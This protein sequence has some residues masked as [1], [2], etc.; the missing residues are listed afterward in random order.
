MDTTPLNRP[1]LLSILLLAPGRIL[2]YSSSI[3]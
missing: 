2:M 1:V 3:Q